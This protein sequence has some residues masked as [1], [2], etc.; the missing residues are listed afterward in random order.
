MNRHV[1]DLLKETL[2]YLC[3]GLF[4]ARNYLKDRVIPF[5]GGMP[6][7]PEDGCVPR[8]LLRR[9]KKT[10]HGNVRPS[11]PEAPAEE[12]DTEDALFY[13][14]I[15]FLLPAIGSYKGSTLQHVRKLVEKK[16]FPDLRSYYG[17][18][19]GNSEEL[20][21]LKKNLTLTGTRFFRGPDW[22][23]FKAECL[24]SFC[25]AESLRVW[26][27]GCSSGKEAYSLLLALSD[28]IPIK[29]IRLLATDHSEDML[30]L[31]R[32][33]VYGLWYLPEI[34]KVYRHRTVLCP[35]GSFPRR[36]SLFDPV[37]PCFTF[38]KDLR[39]RI[40]T[41][42]LDLLTDPYPSGIDIL[43]CRNVIK[44]FSPETIP[45]IQKKLAAS[46]SEGGLLFL[47]ADDGN[48]KELI[49]D[50]E[51]LGLERIGNLPVY[52]KKQPARS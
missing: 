38:T 9:L 18:L 31:T 33:A 35:P 13:E 8:E 39:E 26:C 41:R 20:R 19:E 3:S 48:E 50:P 25:G 46:L 1:E 6:A 44:F 29:K 47:S 21:W 10:V 16:G 30:R 2:A 23:A 17:Y 52:R 32:K 42:R 22:P 43:L 7:R 12:K 15:R 45:E 40:R 36:A 24:S 4:Y 5:L 28:G 11:G 37:K 51:K 27:A 49:R 14:K 34:P